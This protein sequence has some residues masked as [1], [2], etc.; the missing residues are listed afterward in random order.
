MLSVGQFQITGPKRVKVCAHLAAFLQAKPARMG[1]DGQIQH[2]KR[3]IW[4]CTGP[5]K[6]SGMDELKR[7]PL[8]AAHR[9]LAAKMVDFA[10]AHPFL[11]GFIGAG[12]INKLRRR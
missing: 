7:T 9:A 5:V 11:T 8:N 12:I 6:Y 2:A 4:V 1:K 10:M 3:K